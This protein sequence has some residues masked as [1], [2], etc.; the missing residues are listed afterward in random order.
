MRAG[1]LFHEIQLQRNDGAAE[2]LGHQKDGPWTT[3]ATVSAEI[4]PLGGTE[5][6]VAQ[7]QTGAVSSHKITIRSYPGLSPKHRILFG[8]RKFDINNINDLDELGIE[9]TV[10]CKELVN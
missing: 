5:L 7:Q 3:L 10:M 6:L 4:H 2:A 9:M 8:T 1:K